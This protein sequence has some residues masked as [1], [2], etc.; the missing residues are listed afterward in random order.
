MPFAMNAWYVAAHADE[1]TEAFLGRQIVGERVLMTRDSSG[2]VRA[3]NDR[4]PHRF[5]PLHQGDREEDAVVCPY[6]GL[7]FGIKD[8]I[9]S[10]NP[11]GDGRIPGA[12]RVKVYP[13]EER[14]RVIWLWPGDPEKA[15]PSLIP[16]LELFYYDDFEAVHGHIQMGVD[17]RLVLDNLLDLSHAQYI[18]AG[19]LAPAKTKRLVTNEE[20]DDWIKV[21]AEMP[22]SLTTKGQGLFFEHERGDF[23]SAIQWI[24]PGVLRHYVSSSVTG[25]D[26]ALGCRSQNA[27]LITP[28]NETSTHYFW[29]HT[30]GETAK[31]FDAEIN[32]LTRKVINHAFVNEDE[33]MIAECQKYMDGQEFFSLKPLYLSSDY[34]GTRCRRLMERKIAEEQA[35][36]KPRPAQP[37]AQ[38]AE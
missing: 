34:A 3:I 27:H 15:D 16:D 19:T 5:A 22:D 7:K 26:P 4:C 20:G 23:R 12:A 21:S 31:P 25:T 32:E 17:Y 18:H 30:R 38:P 33:P 8:G 37:E 29:I 28:E 10:H 9:C 14:D 36:A 13:T 11:H 1:I 35:A 24:F 6:H 2:S